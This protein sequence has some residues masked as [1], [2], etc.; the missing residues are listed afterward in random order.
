M[1]ET[2]VYGLVLVLLA[3]VGLSVGFVVRE[4]GSRMSRESALASEQLRFFEQQV[5]DSRRRCEALEVSRAA[6]NDRLLDRTLGPVVAPAPPMGERFVADPRGPFSDVFMGSTAPMRD[7]GDVAIPESVPPQ[8][9]DEVASRRVLEAGFEAA[10]EGD[11]ALF[12][13]QG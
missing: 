2:L 10:A 3:V 9:E 12:G 1:M 8:T 6:L 13:S 5:E 4:R 11:A 7:S